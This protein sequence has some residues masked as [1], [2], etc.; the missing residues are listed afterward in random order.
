MKRY[1]PK[2]SN[3]YVQYRN[4]RI[5]NASKEEI[6]LMLYD[7]VLRQLERAD[8]SLEK[9]DIPSKVDAYSRAINILMELRRSLD[10]K[11]NPDLARH[12]EC[13]YDY[14]MVQLTISNYR[15][16]RTLLAQV[17]RMV[18]EL[19]EAWAEAARRY[20]EEQHSFKAPP[21]RS[22]SATT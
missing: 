17:T 22:I 4:Q 10:S 18:R 3:P 7:E 21:G 15:C 2:G 13:L 20:R 12:L 14:M 19:R 8:Q 9:K 6:L 16:D 5:L 11:G 1:P